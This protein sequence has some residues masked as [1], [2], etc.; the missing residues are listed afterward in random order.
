MKYL[1]A[2]VIVSIFCIAVA[3]LIVDNEA[4]IA[5]AALVKWK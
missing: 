3:Y 1:A 2:I 4:L 5:E